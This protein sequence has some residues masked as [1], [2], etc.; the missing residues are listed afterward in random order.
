MGFDIL[1]RYCCSLAL[2]GCAVL[3]PEVLSAQTE[4]GQYGIL[5]Q[6]IAPEFAPQ[7]GFVLYSPV[8]GVVREQLAAVIPN[9]GGEGERQFLAGAAVPLT[10]LSEDL[11]FTFFLRGESGEFLASAVRTWSENTVKK[12]TSPLERL[13]SD[14]RQMA[15][16]VAA[17]EREL[18]EVDSSLKALRERASAVA[19]VDEIVDLKME[20]ARLKGFGDARDQEQQRL[21][22]LIERGRTTPDPTDVDERRQELSR[23]LQ[24]AA[25]VTATAARLSA[26]RKEA[27]KTTIEQKI[28]LIKEMSGQNPEALAQELLRLRERRKALE[29]QLQPQSAP[30]DEF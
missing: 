4:G 26:R 23:H 11:S 24:D 5:D 14:A 16:G 2:L 7:G 6:A 15:E 19:G 30:S 18:L 9:G 13:S 20:L 25:R 21:R 3:A 1:A 22:E 12:N 29:A 10:G 17:S 27:A 8:V 28:A